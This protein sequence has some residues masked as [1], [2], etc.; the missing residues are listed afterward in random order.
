M[1]GDPPLP[2]S[3]HNVCDGCGGPLWVNIG[4]RAWR[5]QTEYGPRNYCQDCEE[6]RNETMPD[7]P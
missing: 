7:L 4:D 1:P 3:E 6:E 2:V 5:V